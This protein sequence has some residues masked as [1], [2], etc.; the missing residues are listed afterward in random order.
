MRND[1]GTSTGDSPDTTADEAM[2]PMGT[3]PDNSDDEEELVIVDPPSS[4]TPSITHKQNNQRNSRQEKRAA[5]VGGIDDGKQHTH[6]SS[7]SPSPGKRTASVG[8]DTEGKQPSPPPSPPASGKRK[9]GKH[10]KGKKAKQ[11][12]D[13]PNKVKQ[14]K[15]KKTTKR[16]TKGKEKDANQPSVALLF[17]SA[18]TDIIGTHTTPTQ[19][20]KVDTLN[21][22][23]R[24]LSPSHKGGA[25]SRSRGSHDSN[26]SQHPKS[27]PPGK[28]GKRQ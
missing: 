8:D 1:T 4:H 15:V 25:R 19:S 28:G 22:R 9:K 7:S 11:G 27:R 12:K 6:T 2:S 17:R 5:S 23:N 21:A 14:D 3:S 24:S 10:K 20:K 18:Q 26:D 16:N 13:K